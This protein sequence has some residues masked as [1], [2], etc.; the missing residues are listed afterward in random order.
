[1]AV[2]QKKNKAAMESSSNDVKLLIGKVLQ[3][4]PDDAIAQLLSKM[5]YSQIRKNKNTAEG[6]RGLG[7]NLYR[8]V[9]IRD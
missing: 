9:R 2:W 5:C 6:L 7:I 8:N 1:M 4:T 3:S